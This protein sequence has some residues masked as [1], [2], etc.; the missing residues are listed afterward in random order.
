MGRDVHL[1]VV[2]FGGRSLVPTPPLLGRL[3]AI[4]LAVRPSFSSAATAATAA[5]VFVSPRRL[6]APTRA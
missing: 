2:P 4:T 5:G 3:I 6:L 1:H